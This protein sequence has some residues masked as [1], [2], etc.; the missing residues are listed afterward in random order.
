MNIPK[1]ALIPA[2]KLTKY[3]LVPKIK[4]DKSRYLARGGFDQ[5]NPEILDAAIRRAI[6]NTEANIERVGE[7]GI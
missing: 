6:E 5:S 7:Y 4:D 3:L 2:A 1:D